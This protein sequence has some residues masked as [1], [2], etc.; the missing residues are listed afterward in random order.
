MA[1][2]NRVLPLLDSIAARVSDWKELDRTWAMATMIS[3]NR[4]MTVAHVLPPPDVPLQLFLPRRSYEPAA[5]RI[6]FRDD[7]LDVAI[8]A[9]ERMFEVDVPIATSPQ[10]GIC[11]TLSFSAEA[12]DGVVA[13]GELV[14]DGAE[15]AAVF[16]DRLSLT[17]G[18]PIISSETLVGIAGGRLS[19]AYRVV[20]MSLLMSLPG[21]FDA[22]FTSP[23]LLDF[24]A[25]DE[26]A[27]RVIDHAVGLVLPTQRL[28]MEQLVLALSA[29]GVVNVP[30]TEL[31]NRLQISVSADAK[32]AS[33]AAEHVAMPRVSAHVDEA[34]TNAIIAAS[35]RGASRVAVQDLL[36]GVLQ[37]DR[38]AVH[39]LASLMTTPATLAISASP[40]TPPLAPPKPVIAGYVSDAAT[41]DNSLGFG[42]Q[43]QDLCTVLAAKAV[44]PPVSVGL[45]GAWGAGKS[46]FMKL[47]EVEFRRIEETARANPQATAFCCRIVQ[48]WFNAWHYI[49]DN[50][51]AGITR[52]IFEGLSFAL[53][54]QAAKASAQELADAKRVAELEET[55]ARQNWERAEEER[56]ATERTL[57][58]TQRTI[59]KMKT[60]PQALQNTLTLRDIGLEWARF[61]T[62]DEEVKTNVQ[63]AAKKLDVSEAEASELL[64]N[65]HGAA[66][67]LQQLFKLPSHRKRA[68]L[69]LL[70]AFGVAVAIY[71]SR[72]ALASI[73]GVALLT[74]GGWIAKTAFQGARLLARAR[75][76][77][78][79][80]LDEKA[81]QLKDTQTA[82]AEEAKRNADEK[83]RLL[84]DA[85]TRA[86]N[87]QPD[88]SMVNF[89]RERGEQWRKDAGVVAA[90]HRDFRELSRFLATL[91]SG[92]TPVDRIVLYIDDL[93][94]CPEEKVFE[95]LRAVHLL[96]AFDLFVVIVAVDP[97]LLLDSVRQSSTR[98]AASDADAHTRAT[99]EDYIEKIIQIPYTLDAMPK[100]RFGDFV[101]SLTTTLQDAKTP[102]ATAAAVTGIVDASAN[103]AAA[104]ETAK[105][106]TIK[107][108][109][110]ATP[111]PPSPEHLAFEEH[112]VNFTT[113][114]Y[115]FMSSPRNT[116]RFVNVYRLLRATLDTTELAAFRDKAAA[117]YQPPQFLSAIITNQHRI[118]PEFCAKLHAAKSDVTWQSFSEGFFPEGT[119]HGTAVRALNGNNA[120]L[121]A[122]TVEQFQ[123]WLPRVARYSFEMRRLTPG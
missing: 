78:V 35:R 38:K 92:T 96:L 100:D 77:E 36:A 75:E 17:A 73:G 32:P 79:E 98:F 103:T 2:A 62:E 95:V 68:G 114:L 34:L 104:G 87:A 47:M 116:K 113:A 23:K 123:A 101:K 84:E 33:R 85:Q 3:P 89:V 110:A 40:T 31:A 7:A 102:A 12:A 93:D 19:T 108:D 20:T 117:A 5:A 21:A 14:F 4:A 88:R 115:P 72:F 54:P 6:V 52:E 94:R 59:D 29:R 46:S 53:T 49:D 44:K 111:L 91:G 67:A 25:L 42:K 112:E 43:A 66:S 26:E 22:G 118:A 9:I 11:M 63:Q 97:R 105:P 74:M 109:A 41:A 13:D 99:A 121:A 57:Q 119:A 48:L 51:Y 37:V 39:A 15:L 80:I 24:R 65:V 122:M 56:K 81:K 18:A 1:I 120:A 45:F 64:S 10:R 82:I 69:W 90:A 16:P 58:E 83:K 50:L 27:A 107:L 70:L 55:I 71:V 28:H 76:R 106:E 61:V 8:L 86:R 30:F 60:D